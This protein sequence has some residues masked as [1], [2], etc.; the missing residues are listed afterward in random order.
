MSLKDSLKSI[1]EHFNLSQKD[2]S[3]KL[4]VSKATISLWESGKKYPSRKNMEKLASTFNISLKDLFD[5]SV[6]EKLESQSNF[7]F[8]PSSYRIKNGIELSIKAAKLS[9]E[10]L[11]VVD[12]AVRVLRVLFEQ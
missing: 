6:D 5:I 8:I 4:E 9:K 10:D 7:E 1:R 11:L 2:L 12:K 3:E